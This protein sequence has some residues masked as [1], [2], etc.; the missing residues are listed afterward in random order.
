MPYTSE[1]ER[2]LRQTLDDFDVDEHLFFNTSRRRGRLSDARQSFF[3]R[4]CALGYSTGQ[5]QR[6][7]ARHG[8][9]IDHTSILT[10]IKREAARRGQPVTR[11]K[12]VA[13]IGVDPGHVDC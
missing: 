7:F 13:V 5:V 10:G 8:R 3:Y 6:L 11:T 9:W 1:I 12:E 2:V 4:V